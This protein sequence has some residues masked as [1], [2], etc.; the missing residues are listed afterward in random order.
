MYVESFVCESNRIEGIM[1][2][3]TAAE[4][5]ETRAFLDLD[6]II[7]SDL[8]RL[9]MVYQ[10]GAQ[11]RIRDG[12]DVRVGDHHPPPGG[13]G[14]LVDLSEILDMQ[15]SKHPYLLHHDYETLHPFID[16]NG[17]SGRALWAWQMVRRGGIGLGRGFLHEFYYQALQ[18]SDQR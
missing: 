9:V 18:F 13:P 6:K 12:M 15:R 2:P 3:P 14:I 16:G 1:R 7:V 5:A 17:R 8:E 11:L 4:L 10:P